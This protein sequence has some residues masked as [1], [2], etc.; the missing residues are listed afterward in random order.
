MVSD[1]YNL[2]VVVVAGTDLGKVNDMLEDIKMWI[3]PVRGT[4]TH[5]NSHVHSRTHTF[6]AVSR[7]QTHTHAH[8]C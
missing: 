8:D 7:T 1:T 6:T 2:S 4:H 5:T 3:E